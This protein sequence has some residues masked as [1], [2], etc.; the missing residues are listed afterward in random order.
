VQATAPE[1]QELRATIMDFLAAMNEHDVERTLGFFTP[2]ATWRQGS[3]VAEGHA[4]IREL[5]ESQWRSTSDMYLPLD[6]VE[7]F[8]SADGDNA[9]TFW[10]ATATMT[11]PFEGFAPTKRRAE[12][13]GACHYRISDGKIAHHL[14]IYDEM[15]VARQFGL[16]PVTASRQYRMMAGAQ[17]LTQ[18]LRRR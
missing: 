14:V 17:R 12:F 5:L 4:A 16:M 6:D 1:V 15:E 7:F 8:V 2:D 18:R 3:A 13:R 10:R 11:G 9:A